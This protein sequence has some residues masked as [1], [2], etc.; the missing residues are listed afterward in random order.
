MPIAAEGT[1]TGGQG[2]TSASAPQGGLAVAAGATAS[3]RDI[4]PGAAAAGLS[5]P[6]SSAPPAPV[7]GAAEPSGVRFS[8]RQRL[9][10]SQGSTSNKGKARP[11][12]S[13]LRGAA[14]VARA[15]QIPAMFPTLGAEKLHDGTPILFESGMALARAVSVGLR[16][17]RLDISSSAYNLEEL[18]DKVADYGKQLETQ[19]KLLEQM[20]KTIHSFKAETASGMNEL[21]Q[22]VGLDKGDV[23]AIK[24]EMKRAKDNQRELVRIR[25][26]LRSYSKVETA[27]TKDTRRAYLNADDTV[28]QMHKAIDEELMLN[29]EKAGAYA[30]SRKVY[31]GRKSKTT[32]AR[33]RTVL[34]RSRS[35]TLQWYKDVLIPVYFKAIGILKSSSGKRSQK[36]KRSAAADQLDLFAE[37]LDK[38]TA[39]KWLHDLDYMKSE[40][41]FP[42][43]WKT[44]IS[45]MELL[46]AS[47]RVV[48]PGN[49]GGTPFVDCTLGH[50][51]LVGAIVRA[52]LEKSAGIKP[53]RRTGLAGGIFTEFAAE[54]VRVHAY[55]PPHNLP[56][57]G[58]CLV[59][60]ADSRRAQL[61]VGEDDM[62]EEYLEEE[63]LNL[64]GLDPAVLAVLDDT[65][66]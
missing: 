25:N 44:L 43:I 9:L 52:V 7:A 40:L 59:D 20:A 54:V 53:A 42:A 61:K 17:M 39:L 23:D 15:E 1:R 34:M 8:P 41:G 27:D 36:R 33:V 30:M 46:G 63:E 32:T 57:R 3:P 31:P 62:E 45:F 16:P 22:K 5:V 12:A 11:G 37:L 65:E 4:S 48:E 60:G 6:R 10:A 29:E 14:A 2:T 56:Y 35:H 18:T 24:E 49:V 38:Q 21:K 13:Q 50:V 55:M 26:R 19:G 28:D 51:A 47:N 58:I 64:A 66:V